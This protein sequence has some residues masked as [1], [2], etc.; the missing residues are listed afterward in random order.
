MI[1]SNLRGRQG[2]GCIIV[3][4][5]GKTVHNVKTP[6]SGLD[7][8]RMESYQKN[9]IN[10]G[11][12]VL[13]G[14]TRYPTKGGNDISAVHPHN[15]SGQLTGVHNGTLRKVRGQFVGNESDS[16]L[17]YKHVSEVG[18]KKAL[19][20]AEGAYALVF[21]DYTTGKLNFIRNSQRP[22][23]FAKV[24]WK[25]SKTLY[26]AS[27]KA[28]L[29]LV[30]DRKNIKYEIEEL[31]INQLW[32]INVSMLGD[33][34]VEKDIFSYVAPAVYNYGQNRREVESN[35]W[36]DSE[37]FHRP[38]G[39]GHSRLVTPTSTV[40]PEAGSNVVPIGSKS[41]TANEGHQTFVMRNGI[42]VRKGQE[43]NKEVSLPRD[44]D[45]VEVQPE[46]T[47]TDGKSVSETENASVVVEQR[48]EVASK[49]R[50]NRGRFLPV[51]VAQQAPQGVQQVTL[52]P[53]EVQW[54]AEAKAAAEW[55]RSIDDDFDSLM[56]RTYPDVT[57]D[58]V[59][60]PALTVDDLFD[61]SFATKK[62]AIYENS[63]IETVKGHHVRKDKV[64]KACKDG[65][66]YC[67]DAV[68]YSKELAWLDD[69]EFLCESCQTSSEAM[70]SMYDFYPYAKC[71]EEWR[72]GKRPN[73]DPIDDYNNYK[74]TMN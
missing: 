21:V 61:K 56:A 28:F 8:F 47:K 5:Q 2:A 18:I 32:T 13:V 26:W 11:P 74:R 7:V 9:V 12:Q 40:V 67:G 34:K 10:K 68:D 66:S 33:F 73:L 35:H 55:R 62:E 3:T 36:Y 23:F 30:L 6:G 53:L 49:A 63:Y 22:L 46:R 45:S 24:N 29:E 42:L 41:S 44:I 31:P 54:E 70:K 14:H 38:I 37:H 71:M 39:S 15:F 65:C 52:S 4:N 25:S 69:L 64:L 43:D 59:V 58:D 20:E 1:V 57:D 27:E 16:A 51:I 72:E 48:E 60:E 19:S 50:D 17:F